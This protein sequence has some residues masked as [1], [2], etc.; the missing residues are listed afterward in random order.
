MNITTLVNKNLVS[1]GCN[2][3][4]RGENNNKHP[5]NFLRRAVPVSDSQTGVQ[6]MNTVQSFA[7]KREEI[8]AYALALLSEVGYYG[9]TMSELARKCGLQKASLY[10]HFESKEYVVAAVIY[11]ARQALIMAAQQA[12]DDEALL[13][14]LKQHID[15]HLKLIIAMGLFIRQSDH[16]ETIAQAHDAYKEALTLVLKALTPQ[17]INTLEP[18][19]IVILW[20]L[21]DANHS[22]TKE[23]DN[24]ILIFPN[25]RRA[26]RIDN[27]S[28]IP[29]PL[30]QRIQKA[31]SKTS[32]SQKKQESD[33][34]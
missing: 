7:N 11:R 5:G 34:A 27:N 32:G 3:R 15:A 13:S 26:K 12:P 19:V 17:E 23:S 4:C 10:H 9:L 33:D 25:K 2:V 22:A 18:S 8:L 20:L 30:N 1:G 24:T 28:P 16:L 29:M 14:G 21:V 31:L 6:R